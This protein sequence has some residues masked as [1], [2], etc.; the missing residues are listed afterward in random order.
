MPPVDSTATTTEEPKHLT[1]DEV[2]A[3]VNTAI[4]ARLK[5]F[6]GAFTKSIGGLLETQLAGLREQ[7]KPQEPAAAAS[8]SATPGA[9][10]GTGTS[11]GN[12][13]W[14]KRLAQLEAELKSH[15]QIAEKERAAREAAEA[16]QAAQEQRQLLQNALVEAKIRPEMLDPA[17]KYLGDKLARDAD[18]GVRWR[19]EDGVFAPIADG[20]RD[21][22][23]T[24]TGMAFLPAKPVRGHE[25]TPGRGNGP[26][27]GN[28]QP[29]YSVADLGALLAGKPP[30]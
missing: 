19:G 21:F 30:A 5:Q 3:L 26:S 14:D 6:E 27:A 24:P 11:T 10:T 16:K 2:N 13:E 23:K 9:G 29:T 25:L 1:A 18:G 15:R 20:V 4:G 28:G 8:G 22:L 17:V 12:P 7:L